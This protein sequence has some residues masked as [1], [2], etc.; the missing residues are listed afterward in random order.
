MGQ[1]AVMIEVLAYLIWRWRCQTRSSIGF[2]PRRE[3]MG[4]VCAGDDVLIQKGHESAE[5]H[6]VGGIGSEQLE[7]SRYEEALERAV[8]YAGEAGVDLWYSD[9]DGRTVRCVAAHQSR[10]PV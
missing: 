9:D 1:G 8:A 7:F 3:A 5:N 6:L 10:S 4:Q 2:A